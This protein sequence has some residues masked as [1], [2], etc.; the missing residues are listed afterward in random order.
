MNTDGYIAP[1][2][3]SGRDGPVVESVI[4]DTRFKVKEPDAA[5]DNASISAANPY[6]K[7]NNMQEA[8]I[9]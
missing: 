8:Q 7:Q 5:D 4:Q 1:L 2:C 6:S 3:R 9:F